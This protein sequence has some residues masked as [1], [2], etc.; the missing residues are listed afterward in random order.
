[1]S[2][3]NSVSNNVR[4]G[5]Y[6][7]NLNNLINS[8][9][10]K[11]IETYTIYGEGE[12]SIQTNDIIFSMGQGAI[13][14]ELFGIPIPIPNLKIKKINIIT[15]ISLNDSFEIGTKTTKFKFEVHN[16]NILVD[17]SYTNFNIISSNI[18]RNIEILFIDD[19][20]LNNDDLYIT[21]K[22]IGDVGSDVRVRFSILLKKDNIFINSTDTIYSDINKI[23]N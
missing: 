19:F 9:N 5:V 14:T 22:Y 20:N 18:D 13:I 23:R 4:Q 1:M 6:E 15:D 7:N 2:I 3:T 17:T 16:D 12:R 10:K 21:S 11:D 8:I